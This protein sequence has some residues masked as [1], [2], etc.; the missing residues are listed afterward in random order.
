MVLSNGSKNAR[1]ASSISNQAQGGGNKKAGFPATVGRSSW[2][3]VA[4]GNTN[5]VTGKCCKLSA[6]NISMMPIA[7][8]SRPI[9]AGQASYRYF[10]PV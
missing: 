5:V 6:Y 10:N 4:F 3:S 9:G 2:T 1:Y 8:I 7:N